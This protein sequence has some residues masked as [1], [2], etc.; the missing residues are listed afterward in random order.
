MEQLRGGVGE[1]GDARYHG[2]R[3]GCRQDF[4]VGVRPHRGE[5]G[6]EERYSARRGEDSGRPLLADELGDGTR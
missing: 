1:P 2:V 5:L 6:D 3:D 4:R